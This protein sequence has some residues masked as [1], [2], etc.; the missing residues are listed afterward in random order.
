MAIKA[1]NDIAG[2]NGLVPIY[3]VFGAYFCISEFDAPAFII[4]KR[5]AA[6]KNV[7]KKVQKVK[8]E[9]Q[10]ADALN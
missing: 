6:I 10:V 2:P 8:A 1:I 5:T 7:M 3:L 9:K 4:T